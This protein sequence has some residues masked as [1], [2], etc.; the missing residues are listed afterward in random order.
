MSETKSLNVRAFE[1]MG[2]EPKIEHLPAQ[3]AKTG[4]NRAFNYNNVP[5]IHENFQLTLDWLM[6]FME[7]Q[8]WSYEITGAQ[9]GNQRFGWGEISIYGST[10]PTKARESIIDDNVAKAACLAA[11]PILEQIAKDKNEN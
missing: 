11:M 4:D 10:W 1:L 5:D 2:W 3:W 6:P 9:F 7:E 8:G